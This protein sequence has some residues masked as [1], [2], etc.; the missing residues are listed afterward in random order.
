MSRKEVILNIDK[1]AF[2]I[3]HILPFLIL[4]PNFTYFSIAA[5]LLRIQ[6]ILTKFKKN[7][8]KISSA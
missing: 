6:N 7:R 2:H 3:I 1:L 5:L 4:I 8:L